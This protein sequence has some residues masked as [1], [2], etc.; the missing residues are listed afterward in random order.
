MILAKI[1]I[2]GELSVGKTSLVRRF[3][4]R[5]FSDRYL[6]TVGVKISRK[7]LRVAGGQ[8]GEDERIQL[9]LW[10]LEGGI[11]FQEMSA[12]YIRGA[13]AA[14]VVGDVTR[15]GTIQA[16]GSHIDHFR[17]VNP[18]GLAIVA[19]NKSDLRKD[20]PDEQSLP[21]GNRD[22]VVA[23][24]HTSALTGEGVDRL[25]GEIGACLLKGGGNGSDD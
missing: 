8:G 4:D 9:I 19:L 2:L 17:S 20:E 22:D 18:A 5:E 7:L 24:L 23:T 15:A 11:G 3:V 10:D 21:W 13:R 12:T 25:F 14:V 6:T 1:C 16:I